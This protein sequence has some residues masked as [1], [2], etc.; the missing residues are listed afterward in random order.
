MA[1]VPPPLYPLS[2]SS[3]CPR[4]EFLGCARIAAAVL[5]V[6]ATRIKGVFSE[7]PQLTPEEERQLKEQNPFGWKTETKPVE[8]EAE[9]AGEGEGAAAAG[10]AEAK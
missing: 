2:P 5:K 10:E 9:A 7:I 8:E 1:L 6:G 3:S 4:L